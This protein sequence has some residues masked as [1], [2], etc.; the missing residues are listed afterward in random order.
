MKIQWFFKC[1]NFVAF[2]GC[3]KAT[4]GN[5]EA[6]LGCPEASWR[7]LGGS[8]RRLG[9]F[10]EGL[11]GILE[12]SWRR[13]GASWTCLGENVEKRLRGVCFLEGF[14]EPKWRQKSLKFALKMQLD[15][16]GVFKHIFCDFSCFWK[17]AGEDMYHFFALILHRFFVDFLLISNPSKP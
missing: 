15:F 6:S 1:F 8:Y 9:G 7:R 3:F 10:L 17:S 2:W 11:R 13:L 12:V 16:T 4:W 5:L 14:W